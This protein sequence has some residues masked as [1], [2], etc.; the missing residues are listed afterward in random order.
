MN[1]LH[2]FVRKMKRLYSPLYSLYR[3]VVSCCRLMIVLAPPGLFILI[4]SIILVF[5]NVSRPEAVHREVAWSNTRQKKV[6]GPVESIMRCIS[7]PTLMSP[8]R[9]SSCIFLRI[10]H[11]PLPAKVLHL[12]AIPRSRSQYPLLP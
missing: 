10:T 12:P 6:K 11:C 4:P 9:H 8:A 5:Y 3:G 1:W 7:F 2:A